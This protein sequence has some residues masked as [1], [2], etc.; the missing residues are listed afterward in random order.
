MLPLSAEKRDT[1][2][3]VQN[4]KALKGLALMLLLVHH[5]FWI[6]N[7][8]YD[9]ITVAHHGVIN[10][11][12]KSCKLCVA[13]F[14]FLSGYGLTRQAKQKGGNH[15]LAAFYRHRLLKLLIN[16]WFIWL[17]FVPIGVFVFG[18][19]FEDSYHEWCVL[20]GIID[21]VGLAF[22]VGF[23][24]YNATWWFMSCIIILYLL[25]PI[26]YKMT[27]SHRD[28]TIIG[29][30]AIMLLPVPLIQY[31]IIRYVPPFILGIRLA[32][33]GLPQNGGG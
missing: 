5:L 7:G 28:L 9:D 16:Y 3:S 23:F 13:I 14:V 6:S 21:F 15:S 20:K 31:E 29:S 12:G 18:R 22:F 25:Y 26:L 17:L 24:G 30:V 19:T 32:I 11:L 8:L 2:L 27:K 4:S 1:H 33:Q 10:E